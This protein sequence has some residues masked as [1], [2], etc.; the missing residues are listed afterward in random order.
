M[1]YVN[2]HKSSLEQLNKISRI[3]RVFDN[4]FVTNR[5]V[6]VDDMYSLF[7]KSSNDIIA[8]LKKKK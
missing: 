5:Y 1:K 4:E 3:H 7:E 8:F 2:H 6:N